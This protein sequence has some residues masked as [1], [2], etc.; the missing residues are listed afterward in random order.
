MMDDS[1][2]HCILSFACIAYRSAPTCERVTLQTT[3]LKG[4]M[5]LFDSNAEVC[6]AALNLASDNN[7]YCLH[8]A[9][10]A[11]CYMV[12]GGLLQ[13]SQEGAATIWDGDVHTP[14]QAMFTLATQMLEVRVA[15]CWWCPVSGSCTRAGNSC[16]CASAPTSLACKCLSSLLVCARPSFELCFFQTASD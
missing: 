3:C 12:S 13:R 15:C 5:Q 11:D 7:I 1:S 6:K 4:S 8:H 10:L 14:A 2:Y 9:T 16:C